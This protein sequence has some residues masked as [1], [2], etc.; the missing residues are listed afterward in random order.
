M[1]IIVDLY[2][3]TVSSQLV[4]YDASLQREPCTWSEV[5]FHINPFPFSVVA[6]DFPKTVPGDKEQFPSIW[7]GVMVG[8]FQRFLSGGGL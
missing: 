2:L 8:A 1:N 7:G 5:M 3:K 4:F 6:I